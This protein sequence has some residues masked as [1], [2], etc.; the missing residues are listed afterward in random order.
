MINI[1]SKTIYGVAA[2]YQLSLLAKGEKLSIKKIAAHANTP[3]RFLEHILL[4]LKRNGI[5]QSAKGARGGYCLCKSLDDITLKEIV[6]ILE[7]NTNPAPCKTGNPVLD[8]FWKERYHKAIKTIDISLKQLDS[9][10]ADLVAEK[11][12]RK[13][14]HEML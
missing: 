12:Q 1:S 5:L 11:I 7:N 8:L 3:Q 10:A 9:C 2:I 14:L 4:A 6:F 13:K